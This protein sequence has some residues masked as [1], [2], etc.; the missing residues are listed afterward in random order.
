LGVSAEDELNLKTML[1]ISLASSSL[2]T[3]VK[4]YLYRTIGAHHDRWAL[5]R[6]LLVPSTA[7]LVQ[8]LSMM[9]GGIP[10]NRRPA[11]LDHQPIPQ[12]LI[13]AAIS[14]KGLPEPL[15]NEIYVGISQG[16][17]DA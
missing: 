11:S 3:A 1:N 4:P 15:M 17:R 6:T 7:Q 5:L 16:L 13:A 2:H 12:A 8:S 10:I 14:G 9:T